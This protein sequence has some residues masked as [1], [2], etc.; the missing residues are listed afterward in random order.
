MASKNVEMA[1]KNVD[2]V[3]K[4]ENEIKVTSMAPFFFVKHR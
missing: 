2:H 4:M 1:S 3:Q